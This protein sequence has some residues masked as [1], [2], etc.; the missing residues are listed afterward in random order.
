MGALYLIV[1][2]D[3]LYNENATVNTLAYISD[4]FLH[5]R[6]LELELLNHY[7]NYI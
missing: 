6:F 5:D 1:C 3:Q 4:Y 7:Q 2:L